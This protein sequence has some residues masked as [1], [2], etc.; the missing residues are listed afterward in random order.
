MEERKKKKKK[1]KRKRDA[2]VKSLTSFSLVRKRENHPLSTV[3]Q[4]PQLRV[5]FARVNMTDPEGCL[6]GGFFQV[7]SSLAVELLD[8]GCVGWLVEPVRGVARG[9]KVPADGC[10]QPDS[11][12]RSTQ[13]ANRGKIHRES[14]NFWLKDY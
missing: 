12:P 14:E 2:E 9:G 1:K 4:R 6:G 3:D 5:G 10:R 11:G 7:P 8:V 13:W